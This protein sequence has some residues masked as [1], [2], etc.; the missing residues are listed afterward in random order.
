MAWSPSR[1]GPPDMSLAPSAP[2]HSID[3]RI[4]GRHM[5]VTL[6]YCTIQAAMA[7]VGPPRSGEGRAA[8]EEQDGSEYR[9]CGPTL[10]E[11]FEIPSN[12]SLEEPVSC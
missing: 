5:T 11:I 6:P 1:L 9:G 3:S 10:E 12:E 7:E 8:E 2:L 4:V